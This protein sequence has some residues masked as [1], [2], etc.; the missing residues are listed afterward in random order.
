MGSL[1]W[2]AETAYAFVAMLLARGNP[3]DA[4]RARALLASARETTAALGLTRLATKIEALTASAAGGRTAVTEYPTPRSVAEPGEGVFRREGKYWT[5]AF[6]GA[7]LRLKD[8]RGFAYLAC[9]LC[10][11]GREFHAAELMVLA[12]GP[13][14]DRLTS[15]WPACPEGEAG[16]RLG[17]RGDVGSPPD[18]CARAAYKARLDELH[19]ELAELSA[20][21]DSGPAAAIQEEIDLLTRELVGLLG[22]GGHARRAGSAAERARL[23]VTR[24][25][26]RALTCV[27]ARD[28]ALGA[29]LAQTV[30]TGTFCSYGRD[31]S[32]VVSWTA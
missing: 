16:Q 5:I 8:V 20:F 3:A 6:A 25:I 10:Y 2:R 22:L 13:D 24:A 1:L 4:E 19:G 23:S 12:D 32:A 29:H 17:R 27:A 30:K 14:P 28:P 7:V 11:P 15:A 26:K 18:A 31:A 9:L 21:R